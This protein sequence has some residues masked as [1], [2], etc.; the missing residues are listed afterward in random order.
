MKPDLKKYAC[1]LTLD[2]NTANRY[3]FLFANNKEVIPLSKPQSYPD[4]PVR[5]EQWPQLRCRNG[6]TGRCYWEVEWEKEVHIAVTY[7][8]NDDCCFGQNK[9]SWSLHCSQDGY[10]AWHNKSK[11]TI[12]PPPTSSSNKVGVYLDWPAGTLSFYTVSSDKLIHL[13]TFYTTF[14]DLL[15]PGFGFWEG[16]GSSLSLCDL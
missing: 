10:Y 14:T 1:E 12:N 6:Q 16:P 4:H 2:P 7:K 3:L 5:Y 15:Y 11:T 9:H 8:D 13:H